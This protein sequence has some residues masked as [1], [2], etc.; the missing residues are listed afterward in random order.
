MAKPRVYLES[1]IISYL[2]SRPSRD[3]VIAGQQ[4][5]TR[6]W[7]DHCRSQFDPVISLAVLEEI[8][9]GD[10]EA[11]A[12]RLETVRDLPLLDLHPSVVEFAA[13]IQEFL[14]I[15]PKAT[16]D[17]LHLSVAVM[18]RVEYLLTWN[19][20]HIANA[21]LWSRLESLCRAEGLVTPVICTP[22]ELSANQP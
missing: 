15:P 18:H 6:Y 11:A 2:T 13:Q 10:P 16:E 14:S 19:C 7:W 3:Q 20:R 9:Q 12:R 8:R 22:Y 1:T 5:L 21:S 17:A 4:E